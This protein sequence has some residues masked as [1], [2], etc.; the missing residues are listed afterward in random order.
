[1]SLRVR[2]MLVTLAMVAVALFLAGWATHAALRS[3][4]I[5]RVD[6]EL[7]TAQLPQVGRFGPDDGYAPPTGGGGPGRHYAPSG[8]RPNT[9]AQIR[10]A[11]GAVVDTILESPDTTVTL[12]ATIR[13]GFSTVDLGG[14]AGE[15]RLLSV[16]QGSSEVD[17]LP[18]DLVPIGGSLVVGVPLGDV[19]D[20]LQ[21]LLVIELAVGALTLGALAV[22]ALWLVRLGLRPLERIGTTADAIAG[23]DLSQRV[24]D[25][26]PRTEVGRLGRTLNTMLD[27]IEKAF[28]ER[29][30]SERRLRQFVG[31]ASHELQTPLTSVRGYAELFRRGAAQRPDDLE[32][33]MRRIEAE[34]A[35]MGVLVDDL[36]LLARLDEG[37]PLERRRLN[38]TTLVGELVGD[39][40]VVEPERPIELVTEGPVEVEG[41]DVRLRQ[42]VSNL[43]SNARSH[44]PRG[45]PVTVRVLAREG[46]AVIE[47][48][49]SGPGMAPEHSQ[50]VFE[51]FFRADASRARSSGGSGL[52]LSIVS[53]ITEAHGGR[54]EVE[55]DPRAG[56]HLPRLPAPHIQL[57][58]GYHAGLR[59]LADPLG[60][61]TSAAPL[62][63]AWNQAPSPEATT[64][65][66]T[67]RSPI[68]V[69]DPAG[70][71]I[72]DIVVPV[73]NEEGDLERSVRR[74][75]AFLEGAFPFTARITIADNASTD[76][77]WDIARRL[78]A[79]LG[80]VEAVRL[81]AKGRGRALRAVW[82]ASDAAVLAYMDVDL[83][84][85]PRRP[86]APRRPAGE[87][88]QRPRHRQPPGARLAGRPRTQ[89]RVHLAV[90]QRAAPRDPAHPLQRRP[91]RLQ[92]DPGRRGARGV[93]AHAGR[94]LVLRHRDAGHRRARGHADPRGPGG[95]G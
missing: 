11:S 74:L 90:L 6:R 50:R 17:R 69:P 95:L 73:Y 88:A 15:Y 18:A 89:A 75:H 70:H 64:A 83:F 1:M 9:V 37:R 32:T 5:D 49:D 3:F 30:E 26:D 76:G 62:P 14:R 44:T 22:L 51:R 38:M 85:R 81:E 47:V 79:E 7:T 36:L 23:G 20:T 41:D 92:G 21:R 71:P 25:D 29:R 8:F 72:V 53:A 66:R 65:V 67:T 45:A 34:A 39:A 16:R 63:S 35:R 12:P 24:A 80:G 33:T 40:R 57:T 68:A 52:G 56:V 93:A 27:S 84:D 28:A 58:G 10:T 55:F 77:T 19:N 78:R 91:V 86:A 82:E 59:S 46:D 13:T 31:D 43:L 4:L 54:T 48:A 61:S 87:R 2:L 60:M 42:V 94:R